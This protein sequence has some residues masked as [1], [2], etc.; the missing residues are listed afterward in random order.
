[1]VLF[2]LLPFL[3]SPN[4]CE[5]GESIAGNSDANVHIIRYA[6][7]LLMY[8]E[9]LNEVGQTGKALTY[10]NRVRERAFNSTEHNYENLSQE[11]FR[12]A[13][14]HERWLE[15]A[16][17]GHRWFDLVRTGRFVQRMKDHAAYEAAVAESNKVE[18]AQNVKDYM[19]LMP[20]P[21]REVDLNPDL[22]QNLGY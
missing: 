6:D 1:M 11:D 4:I 15:L 7:A 9:A 17:E 8:A 18:I 19:V 13:V 12:E 3:S 16:Q 5:Q 10:L 22:K 21:Q 14:W 20:I 2:I